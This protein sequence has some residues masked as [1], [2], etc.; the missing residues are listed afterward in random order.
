MLTSVCVQPTE[1][2]TAPTEGRGASVSVIARARELRGLGEAVPV[3]A[4][5]L[6]CEGYRSRIGAELTPLD[7]WR[8]L[9]LR[10]GTGTSSESNAS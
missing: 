8:A 4:A 9:S 7:V 1:L 3:I 10:H 2:E 5:I 6:N